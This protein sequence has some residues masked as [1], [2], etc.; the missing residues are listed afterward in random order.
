MLRPKM[1]TLYDAEGDRVPDDFPP[2]IDAHVHIFPNAI[3]SAVWKWFSAHAYPIRYQTSASETIEYLLSRGVAHLALLQYA[4]KPG[5]AEELN[6]FMARTCSA[7]PGRTT[8]LA[9]VFPGE[10][11]ASQILQD[12]FD[13]GLGGLKLHAHVQCFDM[14]A[15]C[16]HEIYECCRQNKKP[17][18]VHAGQE[19]NSAAYKCDPYALCSVDRLESILR[20]Y[21]DLKVCV[22]HMGIGETAAYRKLIERYDNLWL[23]TAMAITRYLACSDPIDF[24]R[25]RPDRVM[26]G[27]DFPSIPFAWD[28]ELKKIRAMGLGSDLLDRITHKNAMAFF[29]IPETN[30]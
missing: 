5:M 15:V 25:Y 11:H 19:P 16:M 23:D 3:F 22:P 12:A 9:T 2:V 1:P 26:Y 17:L 8:G 14:N 27:T 7:Y 29:E 21:P 10:D 18:V 20:N 28:R 30:Q 24:G 6:G 4:H 13:A